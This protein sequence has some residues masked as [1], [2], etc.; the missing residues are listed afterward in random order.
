M[1]DDELKAQERHPEPWQPENRPRVLA[2]LGKLAEEATELAGIASRII[3]QGLDAPH[4]DDGRPNRL[5]LEDELADVAALAG[6]TMSGIGWREFVQL[7]SE[8]ALAA[9]ANATPLAVGW[10]ESL[11][12]DRVEA[13][14]EAK[15]RFLLEWLGSL[16]HEVPKE[17]GFRHIKAAYVAGALD[18]HNSP[19]T[20]RDPEFGEAADDYAASKG[21]S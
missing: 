10:G 6:L 21:F 16:S 5:H 4:S 19:S 3:I 12:Y 20:D 1:T 11:D 9:G 14:R 18:V 2:L 15:K 17:V 7:T 13:R 8:E